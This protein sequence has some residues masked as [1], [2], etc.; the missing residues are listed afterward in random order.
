MLF[1][2]FLTGT[3]N[4]GNIPEIPGTERIV[5]EGLQSFWQDDGE[6]GLGKGGLEQN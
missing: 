5:E 1:Q 3:L 6:L 4:R 2:Y